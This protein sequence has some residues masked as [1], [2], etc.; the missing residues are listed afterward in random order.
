M[1][2]ALSIDT[3]PWPWPLTYFKVKVVA[4]PQFSKF[5]CELLLS[6]SSSKLDEVHT[7]EIILTQCVH[8]ELYKLIMYRCIFELF[9]RQNLHYFI[10]VSVSQIH[11]TVGLQD[12][13]VI[14]PICLI[15]SRTEMSDVASST[16]YTHESDRYLFGPMKCFSKQDR[17]SYEVPQFRGHCNLG[18]TFYRT[19]PNTPNHNQFDTLYM[20]F[21]GCWFYSYAKIV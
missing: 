19:L 11:R 8:L 1:W 10:N 4:R 13:Y 16:M 6:S 12:K 15:S 14:G 7:N 2:L 21:Q 18:V 17:M 9:G 3:M 20:Y 5:A